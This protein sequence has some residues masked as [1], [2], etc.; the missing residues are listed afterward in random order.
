MANA[1]MRPPQQHDEGRQ[2]ASQLAEGQPEANCRQSASTQ[3]HQQPAVGVKLVPRDPRLNLLQSP[4]T[5][6]SPFKG[7]EVGDILS[8]ANDSGHKSRQDV[9]DAY[10]LKL[11]S[12]VTI[13]KHM[14]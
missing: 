11:N 12:P 7:G 6:V 10:I 1:I 8:R 5:P 13:I 4:G 9:A 14:V 2:I 3:A